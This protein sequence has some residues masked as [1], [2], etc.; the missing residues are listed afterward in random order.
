MARELEK[1]L[2]PASWTL[3]VE[4]EGKLIAIIDI[5]S[6][7]KMENISTTRRGGAPTTGAIPIHNIRIGER[8]DVGSDNGADNS[9]DYIVSLYSSSCWGGTIKQTK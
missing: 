5:E 4:V 9:D 8:N 7:S 3:Q 1:R 2:L 6:S